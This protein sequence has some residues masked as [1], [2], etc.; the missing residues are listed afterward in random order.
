MELRHLRYFL[1]IAEELSYRKAAA[2][3]H[4]AQ[5]ALSVQI[6][7]LEAE[8]GVSLF[9]REDGR[10][11][12]LTDAGSAF[13]ECARETLTNVARGITQTRQ[14][15]KGEVIHLSLGFVP[16]AE[17]RVLPR[18]IPA[19]KTMWPNVHLALHELKTLEQLDAVRSGELDLG[20]VWLPIPMKDF[21][22]ATLTEDSFVSVLPVG[23]RLASQ[24]VIT[25]KDLS[26]EPLIFF[27]SH[28][29]PDTHRE[30]ERLFLS[31]G[32]VMNVVYELDN[33]PSIINFV[34]MG[35][36]SSLLPAY[37]TSIH[38]EGAVYRP[39]APP[40]VTVTLAVIKKKGRGGVVDS[41]YRYTKEA[42]S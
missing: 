15:A 6:K 36:G 14:I 38:H 25:I 34:A 32:A 16:A 28:I 30:I 29:Y 18:V 10:G 1:A 42:F 21:D 40:N 4:I 20:F 39:L 24:R 8:I 13:L 37:V 2:R 17:H 33:S 23:H 7:Q 26:N 41:I 22:A 3:L 35:S 11:I 12:K 19:F 9:A 27:P 31:G 5:P